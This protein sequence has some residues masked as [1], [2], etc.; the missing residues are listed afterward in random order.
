MREILEH[1]GKRLVTQ[2]H[3]EVQKGGRFI[4][5]FKKKRGKANPNKPY[6]SCLVGQV[7]R[8]HIKHPNYTPCLW[9]HETQA[10]LSDYAHFTASLRKLK[11]LMLQA[12]TQQ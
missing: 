7:W 1:L 10:S 12:V 9:K 5:S 8:N 2:N 11:K 4:Y 6:A 3:P